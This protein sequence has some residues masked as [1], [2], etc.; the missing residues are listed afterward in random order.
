MIKLTGFL[1]LR[2]VRVRQSGHI[3]VEAIGFG[4]IKPEEHCKEALCNSKNQKN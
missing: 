1:H 2:Q 4:T 3:T